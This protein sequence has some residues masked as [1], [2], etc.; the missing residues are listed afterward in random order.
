MRIL[1]VV[2]LSS[3]VLLGEETWWSLRPLVS[4]EVPA[5]DGGWGRNVVDR[6]VHAKMEE[7]GLSPSEEADRAT[8]I[9]RLSYDLTGLPPSLEEVEAFVGDQGED[10]Y[11]RVVER[12]L[13]S[14]AYG[15]HS[16]RHWL[17]VARYAETH[18]YDKDQPREN[19]WPYR[20]Y[21]IRS[22][23]ED[24]R[25]GQFVE[26]QIAGDVLYPEGPDSVVAL[27]FLAAGPWDL[28]A[29]MEVGEEKVDGR[30]AKHL[31]RDEMIA[32]VFN[33]FMSTTV[34][35]A[36]CHDHKI[37]P[38][39]M[40]DYYRLHTIFAAVDRVD[41]AYAADP[42]VRREGLVLGQGIEAKEKELKEIEAELARV[43][44]LGRRVALPAE[45]EDSRRRLEELPTSG[46]VYAIATEFAPS[47][48]FLP[49]KGKLREIRLLDRGDLR[50]PKEVMEPGVPPLWEGV[51]PLLSLPEEHGEGERRA[52]L[53]RYVT[54]RANPLTWRS[55]VNRVWSN[56]FGRGI[57]ATPNDFGRMGE[58]PTHPELLDWLA[59]QFR[60]EGGQSLK[61]LHRLLV[62][63]ATYRQASTCRPGQAEIDQGAR[64][65]WRMNRRRLSAEEIRDSVLLASGQLDRTMGGKSFKDFV[66]EKPMHSPHYQYHLHD[67]NDA[68]SHRRTI[69]RMIVRSQ[70]QPFLTTLDC[71]DPSRS[72][73]VRDESTT[74]L[75]ALALMNNP[76]M[77]V[78]AGQFAKRLAGEERPVEALFRHGLAR[79]PKEL[80]LALFERYRQEHGLEN[81][82][83]IFF[84][85]SEFVYVD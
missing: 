29:H 59:L 24:K 19:A 63:S 2:G 71:A 79:E 77:E 6:F 23:N 16:A 51:E 55:V 10:A 54:D 46:K 8:L 61:G 70:T 76:F 14:P 83:R 4:P 36:Q 60:D 25:W 84:S 64:Y 28:I 78:M 26:E 13:A 68:A 66:I 15:E 32:G 17:D 41:R 42:E 85:L 81:S 31:D 43:G 56:L 62:T 39:T 73:A 80:E 9:R 52:A 67:P 65:L 72:V 50:S 40:V 33:A 49:T 38:I 7:R 69:Y 57:A 34:Q 53:A 20:D 44:Q 48:K 75:Q 37:D 21:V 74:G 3:G 11:E 1:F 12:L 45:L 47:A 18:G 27:G 35:C 22:L 58:L 5:A 30:I 82:C